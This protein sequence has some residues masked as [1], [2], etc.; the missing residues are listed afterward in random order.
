MFE[1]YSDIDKVLSINI[2]FDYSNIINK[3]TPV[4]T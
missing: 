3:R 4:I 1:L 2:Y